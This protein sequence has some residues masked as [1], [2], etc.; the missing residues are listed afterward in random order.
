MYLKSAELQ[1][2]DPRTKSIVQSQLAALLTFGGRFAEAAEVGLAAVS[3]LDDEV[4]VRAL[5]FVSMSLVMSGQINKAL[6]LNDSH[7]EP[8]LRIRRHLPRV[9]GW[10]ITSRS[11]A[12]FFAGRIEEAL[13]LIDRALLSVSHVSSGLL[14]QANAYRGRFVLAL[15]KPRS[16]TRFLNDAL[17]TLRSNAIMEPSWCVALLAEAYALLG[18]FDQAR[19]AVAEAIV[20]DRRNIRFFEP[21]ILRALSWVDAQ[22][23]H[24]SSAVKQLWAAAE[25]ARSRGQLAFEIIILGD[26][27]RFGETRAARRA[28]HLVDQVD[29]GW[30]SAVAAHAA[31]ILSEETADRLSAAEAFGAMGSS[32]AAAELWLEISAAYERGGLPAKAGRSASR[33]AQ[34]VQICEGAQTEAL[35]FMRPKDPLTRR[36]REVARLAGEGM[37]NAQLAEELSV[38]VRTIESH[39]YSA[40]A[41][42]GI[43]DRGQIRCVLQE[44]NP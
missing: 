1:I 8:E 25:L 10:A 33:A 44:Q 42:L 41:K 23:G 20:L 26:L 7:F 2:A 29:G 9:D 31:A 16:A 14:A 36:E 15:G 17:V 6:V 34:L 43:S 32:L 24:V 18:E 3:S 19:A 4:R 11:S 5:A 22:T 13:Q 39:L 12:L 40:F 28:V 38:S 37:T 27:L 21:D 30:S 35:S